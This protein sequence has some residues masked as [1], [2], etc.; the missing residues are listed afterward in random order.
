MLRDASDADLDRLAYGEQGLG[1]VPLAGTEEWQR[2]SSPRMLAAGQR[3]LIEAESKGSRC[4]VTVR[5]AENFTREEFLRNFF[6][7]KKPVLVKGG[8]PMGSIGFQHLRHREMNRTVAMRSV[9]VGGVPYAFEFG[10][11]QQLWTIGEFLE[12]IRDPAAGH[13]IPV[14]A[15]RA[16]ERERQRAGGQV[17]GATHRRGAPN[18][19]GDD[20]YDI[21][22]NMGKRLPKVTLESASRLLQEYNHR[23]EPLYVS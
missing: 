10:Q 20:A 18:T 4:D 23:K 14:I 7:P 2:E 6:H 11:E 22:P 9:T 17:A 21:D 15:E 5:H 8:A 3:V 12:Y 13:M 16:R 19:G 1:Y